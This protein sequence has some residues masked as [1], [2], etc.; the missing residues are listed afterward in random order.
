MYIVLHCG[1]M[2]FNGKTIDERSLGGSETAAYYLARELTRAGHRVTLFTNEREGG[3][4]D[5]VKYA[6]AGQ[7]TD[8]GPL[9]EYF[10]HYAENT[11][12]DVLLIQRHPLA[13]RFPW[14]CK[15]GLWWL[16]DLAL[17]RLRGQLTASLWNMDGIV[18]VSEWHKQQVVDAWGVDEKIVLPIQNGVDLALYDNVTRV[19]SEYPS[20]ARRVI[21]NARGAGVTERDAMSEFKLL[22]AARPERGLINL[23]RDGGIMERLKKEL[24]RAHLYLCTYDNAAPQL[25]GLYDHLDRRAAELGNVT[26]LGHLTKGQLAMV[27]QLCDLY[28][29][30]TTFEDTSCIAMMECAAAGLPA[31]ISDVAALPETTRDGGV[32]RVPLSDGQVNVDEFVRHITRLARREEDDATGAS[33]L[34]SLSM[35]QRNAGG[36]FEWHNAAGMLLDHVARIFARKQSNDGAVLR[37]LVRQSDVAVA[38]DIVACHYGEVSVNDPIVRRVGTEL[39]DCYG[40]YLNDTFEEHYEKYYEY[41]KRRGVV[42][43]PES[44]D[45]NLRFEHV[46]KLVGDHTAPGD[47]VVD[48]GCAHGHYAVNLARRLPDRR[49]V[50]IDL[51]QSNIDAARAWA[52]RD[53]VKNVKFYRG[54]N[55]SNGPLRVECS[56][57]A[58][59][60]LTG[61]A[62]VLL[63]AEVL[64]HVAAP[65]P[66]L[67]TLCV[68][69]LSPDGKVIVTTPY[70][71]WEAQGYRQHH[72]W[73]AHLHHL[74]REDLHD[75]WGHQPDFG[76]TVVPAGATAE[77]EAI[78]S[79]VTTF[80]YKKDEGAAGHGAIN[81]ERKLRLLSP[82]QTLSV[83]YIVRNAEA[84]LRRSLES[85]RDVADEIVLAVDRTTTDRTREIIAQ[86]ADDCK[87]WPVVTVIEIDSP[88][89]TGFDAARNASI[90]GAA[91]EWIMWIDAD[92][93]LVG[94][95]RLAKY[96]RHNM[97]DGYALKQH[98]FTMEPLGVQRT[99]LPCRLFRN[100]RGVYFLGTVHEHPE[101]ALNKGVGHVTLIHDVDIAHEGYTTDVI[102]RKRFERNLPLIQRDREKNPERKLGKFLWLRDLAQ[103]CASEYGQVRALTPGL[104]ARADE[105]VRLF[106][107]LLRDPETP[108]NLL[109]DGIEFYHVVASVQNPEGTEI[110]FEFNASKMSGE[111][112]QERRIVTKVASHDHARLIMERVMREKLSRFESRYY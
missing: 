94:G 49:F 46:A 74:E 15:V 93:I 53:N 55:P 8:A 103:L 24:P 100:R 87:L 16:H 50:G 80:T 6:W 64:E 42:Y 90:A 65:G 99:D 41:E 32:I 54:F 21:L 110:G 39:I 48:Y 18:T 3:I 105:G 79:Y 22:Y 1:G 59:R 11:P 86:F 72:P 35:R 12:H 81:Y 75:L 66:L 7:V 82:R 9:G 43:G 91:G 108:F 68:K 107:E 83:C 106:D 57:E 104:R 40:F 60:A 88:L 98:H 56:D 28:V 111:P 45:G 92:E 34:D 25:R 78:G 51:V 89:E 97:F 109:M 30:P 31:L 84:T 67:D 62:R 20:A 44:L 73:R 4:W 2:P 70:G 27:Q 37:G 38:N 52:E 29:Y 101:I 63:A 5:G 96:L 58:Q 85:V 77:G 69:F 33:E 26:K 17:G 71:P 102:R 76:I 112:A 10:H 14:A 61:S 19:I 47:L 95:E 36:R 23:L 13:F